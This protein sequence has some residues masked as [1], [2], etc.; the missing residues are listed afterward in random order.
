MKIINKISLLYLLVLISCVTT[1]NNRFVSIGTAAYVRQDSDGIILFEEDFQQKNGYPAGYIIQD[2]AE[3]FYQYRNFQE[4]IPLVREIRE[5][6]FNGFKNFRLDATVRITTEDGG[7]VLVGRN[8]ELEDSRFILVLE[9]S[10]AALICEKSGKETYN[11]SEEIY[12]PALRWSSLSIC[13]VKNKLAIYIDNRLAATFSDIPITDRGGYYLVS[14]NSFDLK[15]LKAS[16][17]DSWSDSLKLN[18]DFSISGLFLERVVENF[19][20]KYFNK[21]WIV[22]DS[23]KFGPDGSPQSSN[24][25]SQ[26]IGTI[27]SKYPLMNSGSSQYSFFVKEWTNREIFAV[28]GGVENYGG[29][30]FSITP[31][32]FRL[33]KYTNQQP[34]IISDVVHDMVDI[35][36]DTMFQVKLDIMG[37]TLLCYFN[38]MLIFREDDLKY[39]NGSVGIGFF[40]GD[41]FVNVRKM[42]VIPLNSELRGIPLE[43][44]AYQE[45]F[46]QQTDDQFSEIS[47]IEKWYFWSDGDGIE[48]AEDYLEWRGDYFSYTSE[49]IEKS[50][51]FYVIDKDLSNKNGIEFNIMGTEGEHIF[52]YMD[53][54]SNTPDTVM[55]RIDFTG[56]QQKIVIPFEDAS[57]MIA[58]DG[59][60]GHGNREFDF[61]RVGSIGFIMLD[62]VNPFLFSPPT[63]FTRNENVTNDRT[64]L[65]QDLRVLA[66]S[67]DGVEYEVSGTLGESETLGIF[68][69]NSSTSSHPGLFEYHTIEVPLNNQNIVWKLP[70]GELAYYNVFSD[71]LTGDFVLGE[72]LVIF[73]NHYDPIL[74]KDEFIE[75]IRLG[76]FNP[77][78][79]SGTNESINS[80]IKTQFMAALSSYGNIEVE[81]LEGDYNNKRNLSQQSFFN[82]YLSIRYSQSSRFTIYT[83]EFFDTITGEKIAEQRVAKS[84]NED[85]T[86]EI[87]QLVDEFISTL[88]SEGIVFTE[89]KPTPDDSEYLY[90][91]QTNTWIPYSDFQLTDEYFRELKRIKISNIDLTQP[92]DIYWNYIGLDNHCQLRVDGDKLYFIDHADLIEIEIFSKTIEDEIE[93][94]DVEEVESET[95][96][97]DDIVISDEENL[98][99]I[100]IAEE[101]LEEETET[102]SI[103]TIPEEIDLEIVWISPGEVKLF[104]D[105]ELVSTF[106]TIPVQFGRIGS[107]F[108]ANTDDAP[109]IELTY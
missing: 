103:A 31:T 65:R 17:L 50:S 18:D 25:R 106:Q 53:E 109:I 75:I 32:R 69:I 19:D 56:S 80:K 64:I 43:L 107:S 101:D 61:S 79:T 66:S 70:I 11:R 63:T 39:L 95:I 88:S 51:L 60:N 22:S 108:I 3:R 48:L 93:S 71:S 5:A 87:N 26:T 91:A 23:I 85:I 4:S 7:I 90:P 78:A 2:G 10:S 28:A 62:A 55:K 59:L 40:E 96:E 89:D 58:G 49:D 30:L 83:M 99:S 105:E 104:I 81:Q 38:N 9:N 84:S 33:Y 45:P 1:S 47:N 13:V 94:I 68:D 20:S 72:D 86:S 76:F 97:A 34:Q 41:E 16:Q 29:Y 24:S 98:E 100:E 57:L 14:E 8:N 82:Y 6:N 27:I 37:D 54:S 52:F 42:T 102:N 44:E 77:L 36:S 73:D 92:F 35:G 74:Y 15:Y 21:N 67:Y 46:V 12:L